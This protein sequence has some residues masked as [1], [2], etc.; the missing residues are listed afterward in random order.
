MPPIHGRTCKFS[1]DGR[2]MAVGRSGVSNRPACVTLFKR[3]GDVWLE[4]WTDFN[5]P[6]AVDPLWL[7]ADVVTWRLATGERRTR[8]TDDPSGTTLE[9]VG[10]VRYAAG[11]GHWAITRGGQIILDGTVID[12]GRGSGLTLAGD[13]IG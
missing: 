2:F 9:R 7:S 5:A 3:A 12:T 1:P 4:C 13:W 10:G 8:G 11:S 6:N